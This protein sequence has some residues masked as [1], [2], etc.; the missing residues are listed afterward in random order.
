MTFTILYQLRFPFLLLL[1]LPLIGQS[2]QSGQPGRPGE[3][4]NEDVTE[5]LDCNLQHSEE[6]RS[7]IE[8][9][10]TDQEK[11]EAIRALAKVIAEEWN[12]SS[13]E[14]K[15]SIPLL[16]WAPKPQ[17]PK[18]TGSYKWNLTIVKGIV[19]PDGRASSASILK[20]TGSSV[21]DEVCL[22]LF[23]SALFRPA[24]N[25][26]EYVS[27]SSFMTCRVHPKL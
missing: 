11:T 25:G 26:K 24:R 14:H 9:T 5:L 16:V 27:G 10:V 15:L 2:G 8:H 4:K 7:T 12:L 18:K 3:P 6:C 19:E 22:N 13:G 23:K 17:Y 1:V 21:V 20:G